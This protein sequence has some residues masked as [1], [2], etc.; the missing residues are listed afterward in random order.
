MLSTSVLIKTGRKQILNVLQSILQAVLKPEHVFL[1]EH[2]LIGTAC[3][4]KLGLFIKLTVL[5]VFRNEHTVAI[6][7]LHKAGIFQ[8]LL[9]TQPDVTQVCY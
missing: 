2:F 5:Q 1:F 8:A 4:H 7:V 9:S 6:N 3:K